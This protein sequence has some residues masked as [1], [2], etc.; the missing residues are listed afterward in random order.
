MKITLGYDSHKLEEFKSAAITLVAKKPGAIYCPILF[1]SK[2][3]EHA[4]TTVDPMA[5]IM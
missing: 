1:F 2:N 5:I 4:Q 3:K